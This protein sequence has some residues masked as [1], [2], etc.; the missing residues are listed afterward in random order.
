MKVQTLSERLWTSAA[1]DLF[2]DVVPRTCFFASD[3][4]STSFF[5]PAGQNEIRIYKK[6]I[7][8]FKYIAEYQL[9]RKKLLVSY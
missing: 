7:V 2:V 9:E 1:R 6:Q 4:K 8:K 5:F 3:S